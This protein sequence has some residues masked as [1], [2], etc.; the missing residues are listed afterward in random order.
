MLLVRITTKAG[1]K[2]SGLDMAG[3]LQSPLAKRIF[4]HRLKEAG[5]NLVGRMKEASPRD[6]GR[7]ANS[8]GYAV[9][10]DGLRLIV[11]NRAEYAVPVHEGARYKNKMPPYEALIAWARRHLVNQRIATNKIKL[12]AGVALKVNLRKSATKDEQAQ[13]RQFAFLIARAIRRRGF[14]PARPWFMNVLKDGGLEEVAKAVS[15][16]AADCADLYGK[17]AAQLMRESLPKEGA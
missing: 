8:H 13:A 16:A 15:R 9:D 14:T 3:G 12:E 17:W 6:T 11:F 7:L 4:A 10:Q 1:T 5:T 2:E